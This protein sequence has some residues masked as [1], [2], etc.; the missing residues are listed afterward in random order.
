MKAKK[1]ILM[2]STMVFILP[3]MAQSGGQKKEEKK[4]MEL[5]RQWAKAAQSGS[6]DQ[7]V[8]FWS[9]DAVLMTPDQGRIIGR[10]QLKAMV[11]GSMQIPGFEIDWEPQ[12][13]RVA[14]SGD[15][16]YVIA[17][18]YVKVPNES[19]D[20]MTFYFVEVGIW[21]KQYDGTWKNTVDIYNPDASI[22][23]IDN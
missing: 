12:K 7:I 2:L 17:H 3:C 5:S 10:E 4:L 6:A 15:L 1:V 13:A 18:K 21:E 20:V 8:S 22:T 11:D 14:A 16:G 23:S 9:E 19:G